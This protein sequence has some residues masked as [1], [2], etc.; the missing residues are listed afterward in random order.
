MIR[1]HVF[2]TK[3]WG[4]PV[5]I[6]DDPEFFQQPDQIQREMLSP[7]SWVEFRSPMELTL[8]LEQIHQ[9]GFL[10]VDTQVNF[11]QRE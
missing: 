6:I 4:Q 1:E 7:Y 9:A 2:N 8:S 3:W 10:H 11:L 5:G